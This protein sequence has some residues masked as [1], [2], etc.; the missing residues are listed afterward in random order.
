VTCLV[1]VLNPTA[2][3]AVNLSGNGG[4]TVNG[5]VD[6]NSSSSS[7]LSASGQVTLNASSIGVV[8]GTNITKGAKVSPKPVTITPVSDPFAA[9]PTPSLSGTVQPPVS[10]GSGTMS[11]T[12]GIYS[13]I[14]VSGGTLTLQPGTYVV[15]QSVSVTGG[16]LTGSG[17]T[18]YLACGTSS[19]AQACASGQSG[20]TFSVSGQGTYVLS[21]PTS[22]T[23]KGL[24][25]FADRNN[26][27]ALTLSAQ[28]GDGLTGA[29]YEK[30]GALNLSGNASIT[31]QARI[32]VGTL[33]L[34]GNASITVN[35]PP[36]SAHPRSSDVVS[37]MAAMISGDVTGIASAISDGVSSLV[38]MIASPAQYASVDGG[39]TQ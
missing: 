35:P 3:A 30:S 20:A 19:T 38:A 21:A 7:A 27:S 10:L 39:A 33:T 12:P 17:V 29:I 31:I 13:S 22:G 15:T 37:D 2:S 18:I 8:G 6:V 36:S 9:V 32:V 5:A 34:S 26:T 25:I 14:T 4:M 1:C 16:T 28:A 24:T 23:F 11:I